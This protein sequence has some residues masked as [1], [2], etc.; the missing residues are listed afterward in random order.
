M[1]IVET[2]D[3]AKLV[4]TAAINWTALEEHRSAG[5]IKEYIHRE[6]ARQVVE[7]MK[8]QILAQLNFD[9]ILKLTQ[10]HLAVILAADVKK[11]LNNPSS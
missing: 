6:L 3:P 8:P 9:E 7:S 2:V 5:K 1:C 11:V 10:Q 4:K